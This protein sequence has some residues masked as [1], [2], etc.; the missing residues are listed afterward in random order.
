VTVE[1]ADSLS[2]F[3]LF[4]MKAGNACPTGGRL[5]CYS[6]AGLNSVYYLRMFMIELK[7][8]SVVQKVFNRL[9][10]LPR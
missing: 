3:F 2:A 4:I 7:T 6:D 10:L 9:E 5:C 1:G 8:K